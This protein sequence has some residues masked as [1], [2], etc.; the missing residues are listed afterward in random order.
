MHML[1][2]IEHLKATGIRNWL[3][4][5]P[6]LRLHLESAATDAQLCPNQHAQPTQSFHL[7][8][9]DSSKVQLLML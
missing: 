1:V 8:R 2:L 5:P 4:M 3:Q 7:P 6:D 9:V